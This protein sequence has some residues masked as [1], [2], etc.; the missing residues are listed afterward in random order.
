M[1]DSVSRVAIVTG[2]ASGIGRATA[3]LLA[4]HGVL[5]AVLDRKA[6]DGGI[7]VDASDEASVSRAV[8][9]VRSTA[10]AAAQEMAAT[11]GVPIAG[12]LELELNTS[13]SARPRRG[14]RREVIG[15][16][17]GRQRHGH[18]SRAHRPR[19][20][21]TKAGPSLTTWRA[22][23]PALAGEVA[24][25]RGRM[26]MQWVVR[27]GRALYGGRQLSEWVE[28]L[29]DEVARAVDPVAVWLI[30]SVA[31]G[32]DG[33]H[34]DID[35]LVLL[36]SYDPE[37]GTRLKRR[38]YAEVATPVPFDIAFSDPQRFAHRSRVPGTLE[39]AAVLDGRRVYEHDAAA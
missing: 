35:L 2:G 18:G 7:T 5:V 8:D 23:R 30:G 29:V 24:R 31:R 3:E 19:N 15:S 11:G 14:G 36:R 1:P 33:P 13:W 39:R 9:E 22:A 16:E 32:D 34:S 4:A 10:Q 27:D 20:R 17:H 26:A 37:E 21:A 38:V 6:V 12:D 25:Y 28:P